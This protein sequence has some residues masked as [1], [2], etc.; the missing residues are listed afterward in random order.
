MQIEAAALVVA[1]MATLH[2]GGGSKKK[3]AKVRR[4]MLQRRTSKTSR[5]KKKISR[6]AS[7]AG[8]TMRSIYNFERCRDEKVTH[9][10]AQ[11]LGPI[12]PQ[13]PTLEMVQISYLAICVLIG[14]SGECIVDIQGMV[15]QERYKIE[16][17]EKEEEAKEAQKDWSESFLQRN[18]SKVVRSATGHDL[19]ADSVIARQHL[20]TEL[21]VKRVRSWG[22]DK[23]HEFL[24]EM[25]IAGLV[26]EFDEDMVDGVALLRSMD[27]WSLY[28]SPKDASKKRDLQKG[29]QQL[30]KT[31][32]SKVTDEELEQ[33]LQRKESRRALLEQKKN[34]EAKDGDADADVESS[35]YE[36][37]FDLSALEAGSGGEFDD[38]SEDE[39][40][41]SSEDDLG[42]AAVVAVADSPDKAEESPP[43]PAP[44]GVVVV[45]NPIVASDT[46]AAA[47][48]EDQV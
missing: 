10:L 20:K 42:P 23:V 27:A 30:I 15:R 25:G 21:A 48:K 32:A 37:S 5:M 38:A 12:M 6:K 43:P 47:G 34:G 29:I 33:D 2:G 3:H 44:P 40:A 13:G 31:T 36:S 24:K 19:H 35:S 28:F 1:E 9:Q 18:L 26:A 16:Q 46:A 17:Q 11:F 39:K 4:D 8:G 14:G 45:E 7:G 41:G 22:K